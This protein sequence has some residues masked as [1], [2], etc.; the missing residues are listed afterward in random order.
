MKVIKLIKMITVLLLNLICLF[1]YQ[2]H[3]ITYRFLFLFVGGI[4]GLVEAVSW[5]NK[6]KIELTL[7]ICVSMMKALSFYHSWCPCL[8]ISLLGYVK[9][10]THL[11]THNIYFDR[12][13]IC[14]FV[15]PSSFILCS[16][17]PALTVE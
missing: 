16:M 4:L 5:N 12:S 3:K 1:V 17:A 8:R 7:D 11:N 13:P 9:Y 10:K 14:L 15:H 2:W 6:R